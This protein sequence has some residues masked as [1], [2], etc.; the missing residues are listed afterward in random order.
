MELHRMVEDDIAVIA[1]SG[2]L[3]TATAPEFE[4]ES[5]LRLEEGDKKILLELSELEYISSAGLRAI[6]ALAKGAKA[7]GGSVAVCAMTGMVEEVFSISGFDA[8][9]PVA[10]TKDEGLEALR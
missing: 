3:D 6:L 5:L 8:F 10:S 2:R 1:V 4:R 7:S 9:I